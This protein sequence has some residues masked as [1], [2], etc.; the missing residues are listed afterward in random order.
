MSG[1]AC[2]VYVGINPCGKSVTAVLPAAPRGTQW[3]VAVYTG[4]EPGGD[5]MVPQCGDY[6]P[7]PPTSTFLLAPKAA[8][9]LESVPLLHGDLPRILDF[10]VMTR[11]VHREQ[12]R[13]I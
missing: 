10:F 11:R 2:A 7:L 8:V 4:G 1:G 3:R 13:R 6:E 5:A 9:C 12:I